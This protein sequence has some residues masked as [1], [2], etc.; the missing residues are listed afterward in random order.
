MSKLVAQQ[1]IQWLNIPTIFTKRDSEVK[2]ITHP[3]LKPPIYKGFID[4]I[5]SVIKTSGGLQE[6]CR[7]IGCP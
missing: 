1:Q 7:G 3:T 4:H 2:T 6:S 5:C